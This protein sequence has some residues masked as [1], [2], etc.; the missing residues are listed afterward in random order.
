M[1]MKTIYVSPHGDDCNDGTARAPLATLDRAFEAAARGGCA[2]IAL[3][4]GTYRLRKTLSLSNR[5][6]G[7]RVAARGRGRPVVSGMREI[8]GWRMEP[9]GLMSAPVRW[10]G[11]RDRAFRQFF[12][13]G[14]ECQRAA[15]PKSGFVETSADPKPDG[16]S[17]EEWASRNPRSRI[18]IAPGQMDPSWDFSSSEFTVYHYWVDSHLAPKGVSVGDDGRTFVE[19]EYPCMRSPNL[20]VARFE[21][22]R[23]IATEPGEWAL[24]WRRGRVYYRPRRGETP[25]GIR[26]EAPFVSTLLS[27]DGADGIAFDGVTFTGARFDLPWGERNDFQASYFVDSAIKLRN[28]RRCSFERCSIENVDGYAIDLLDG[29]CECRVSHCTLSRLGAGGVRLNCG[30]K[31]W[32]CYGK[33][34]PLTDLSVCDPRIRVVGNEV[35]DCTIANYG[36]SFPSACGVFLANAEQTRIVHNEIRDGYYTGVSAGWVWGYLPSLS[37][38]NEISFN[39][40]HDIGKGLLS[41][42]GGIYTLGVSTGTVVANNVIHDIDARHYGGWG[43]YTDE[44]STGITMERNVVFR[45]KFACYHMHYGRDCIIRNNVFGGGRLEQVV[46][47]RREGH[48]SFLF[49]NNVVYWT[50][51]ELHKGNWDDSE[52]YE[53]RFHP[54]HVRRLRKTTEC[55]WNLY[56]NPCLELGDVRFGPNLTWEEWKARGQDVHSAWADPRFADPASGD[57]SLAPDSPVLALGFRPIDVSLVG[58]RE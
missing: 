33:E 28:A 5:H 30:V 14:R 20:T 43:L 53:F 51:G 38:R 12:V 2:R 3:A 41:D 11:T 54:D 37:F 1:K 36:R 29:T 27:I 6:S 57:F 46:R 50:E 55:D 42:M 25:Q 16:M 26:A 18:E 56:Y 35:S 7:I 9:D 8:T 32:R 24:D 23:S 22:S 4:G 44:G 21:N 48:L 34:N 31:Y 58:P 39:H 19:L 49:Y 10:A 47:S 13:N 45:T 52:D 17:W 15:W 40:I